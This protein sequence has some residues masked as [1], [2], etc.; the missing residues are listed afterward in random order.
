MLATLSRMSLALSAPDIGRPAVV[1]SDC[2]QCIRRA[3]LRYPGADLR[4]NTA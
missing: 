2:P 4:P 1:C 3:V